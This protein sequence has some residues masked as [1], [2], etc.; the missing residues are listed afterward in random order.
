MYFNFRDDTNYI[1]KW[2]F[3]LFIIFLIIFVTIKIFIQAYK[4]YKLSLIKKN[5]IN[6]LIKIIKSN[7]DEEKKFYKIKEILL[8]NSSYSIEK[9][10]GIKNKEI[11][12]LIKE[13]KYFTI[14]NMIYYKITNN[15]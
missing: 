8:L 3:I 12:D 10:L 15:E 2:F 13:K 14:N 4:K 7:E 6:N 1:L 9:F 11:L 5:Q